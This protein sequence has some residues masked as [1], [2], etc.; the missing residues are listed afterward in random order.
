MTYLQYWMQF[1]RASL[2]INAQKYAALMMGKTLGFSYPHPLDEAQY[3]E[4]LTAIDKA[5][6][7]LYKSMENKPR[8]GSWIVDLDEALNGVSEEYLK[9]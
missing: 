4:V 3:L 6:P 8:S 5:Y 9:V 7:D 1:W 2:D